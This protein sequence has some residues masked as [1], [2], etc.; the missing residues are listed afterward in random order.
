MKKEEIT[1]EL[2]KRFCKDTGAPINIYEEP[3]FTSRLELLDPLFNTFAE[4]EIYVYILKMFKNEQE[5][6]EY[7][8]KVKNELINNIKSKEGYKRFCEEDMYKFA[9]KHSGLLSKKDIYHQENDGKTFISIDMIQANFNALRYYDPDIFACNTWKDFVY[10]TATDI[11]HIANS[12]YIRQIVL[13]NCNCK[14]QVDLEKYIMDYVL[15]LAAYHVFGLG[16]VVFFSNDEIIIKV[17][18]E[19][20]MEEKYSRVYDFIKMLSII[21]LRTELF[22]LHKID[23]ANGYVKECHI[24][25][26]N[27]RGIEER[28]IISIK[29]V[30]AQ[31]YPFVVRKLLGQEIQ[32]EDK[33]FYKDGLLCKYIDVPKIT[34]SNKTFKLFEKSIDS[35]K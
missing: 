8:N 34:I 12:K 26:D 2:R 6:F 33:V 17:D 29:C 16:E 18:S 4:W 24:K 19:E 32:E 31:M 15:G 20:N 5:Y 14:R 35:T 30:D 27:K 21:P 3:Y 13:G 9:I 10:R 11:Y 23:G 1:Q 25:N 7:Y 22:T 28:E